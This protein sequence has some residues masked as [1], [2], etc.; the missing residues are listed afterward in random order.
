M[1]LKLS[2]TT[3]SFQVFVVFFF[4]PK[5]KQKTSSLFL[6]LQIKEAR[7]VTV[8]FNRQPANNRFSLY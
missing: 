5:E 6:P 8:V 2:F 7:K 3:E 4:T 1:L